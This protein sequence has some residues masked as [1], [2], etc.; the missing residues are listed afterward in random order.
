MNGT[1]RLIPAIESYAL[2]PTIVALAAI[3]IDRSGLHSLLK[4]PLFVGLAVAAFYLTRSSAGILVVLAAVLLDKSLFFHPIVTYGAGVILGCYFAI[5]GA[6]SKME[7]QLRGTGISLG[8]IY[9]LGLLP[10]LLPHSVLRWSIAALLVLSTLVLLWLWKTRSFRAP[11]LA[12][13]PLAY[14][15]P[16]LCEGDGQ[17]NANRDRFTL[18]CVFFLVLGAPAWG[19]LV[20]LL[21]FRLAALIHIAISLVVP[22]AFLSL[23][24][25]PFDSIEN[26]ETFA[27][28]PIGPSLEEQLAALEAERRLRERQELLIRERQFFFGQTWDQLAACFTNHLQTTL[29]DGSVIKANDHIFLGVA[30]EP[31]GDD[32]RYKAIFLHRPILEQ[33]IHILGGTGSGKTSLGVMPIIIQLIRGYAQPDPKT[34]GI[35]PSDKQ[36][37]VIFDVKGDLALF[38]TARKEAEDRGQEFLFFNVD[39]TKA[40]YYFN[41]FQVLRQHGATPSEQAHQLMDALSLNHGEQYGGSYFTRMNRQ[42]L[43]QMLRKGTPQSFRDLY[44]QLKGD[45]KKRKQAEELFAALEGLIDYP[46]LYTTKEQEEKQPETIIDFDRM[47]DRNQVVY[48]W[49]TAPTQSQAIREIGKLAIYSFFMTAIKRHAAGKRKQSYLIIDEFQRLIGENLA[50]LVEQARGFGIGAILANQNISQL[51]TRDGKLW[52]LVNSNV[53]AS[54]HFGSGDPDEK[55]LLSEMSGEIIDY[56]SSVTA[57]EG[58]TKGR[59][60]AHSSGVTSTSGSSGFSSVSTSGTTSGTTE[61][62]SSSISESVADTREEFYRPRFRLEDLNGWFNDDRN[63]LFWVRRGSGLSNFRGLPVK[64]E[65]IYTIDE[66][67]YKKRELL[68]WPDG[69]RPTFEA[70]SGET[71]RREELLENF[72]LFNEE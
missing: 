44:N 9:T 56:L 65:G 27:L 24:R 34:G 50:Q 11:E 55:K 46:Q 40:S 70:S 23:L 67:T 14:L 69:P 13:N 52:S 16:K 35:K 38:H 28:V 48:F 17:Y 41:P 6:D 5:H 72:K 57:T 47:F 51:D 12:M 62:E 1:R 58:L 7:D 18:Y 68:P 37:I 31:E 26:P 4:L 63:F 54:L 71:K 33:H 66:L 36:P 60:E 8:I 43:L 25:I 32:D 45:A 61:S 2:F 64:V 21:D 22:S 15:D 29:P 10:L 39:S 53:R 19:Q 20:E 42:P 59:S 3:G 49:L 30:S